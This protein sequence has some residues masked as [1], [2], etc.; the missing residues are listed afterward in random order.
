MNDKI[1]AV[2][3]QINNYNNLLIHKISDDEKTKQLLNAILSEQV[4]SLPSKQIKKQIKKVSDKLMNIFDGEI[5][6]SK[7]LEL[8]EFRS[9]KELKDELKVLLAE[10]KVT[11]DLL[12]TVV[13]K[14]KTDFKLKSILGELEV[15]KDK[16]KGIETK[17]QLE[18]AVKG[19]IEEIKAFNEEKK[20]LELHLNDL[21]KEIASKQIMLDKLNEEKRN[22]EL[23]V[24]EL[25][26]RKME[27]E[28][29]E[30]EPRE[31]ETNDNLDYIYSKIQIHQKDRHD[32]KA[33][34]DVVFEGLKYR[35]RSSI[36]DEEEFIRFVE[37]EIA[38]LNDKERS[39]DGLLSSIS[40]QFA[41]PAFT[42]L[43][44]YEEFK[45][46]VYDKFNTKL[47]TTRISNIESLKIDIIDNDRIISELKQISSIQ[48]FNGQMSFDFNQSENLK[49]LNNYL[50][51]G[52]K[53]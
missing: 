47:A 28:S 53:V 7:G 30:V 33:N 8:T 29:I 34:K 23:R 50:D 39:I 25:K 48:E 32:L 46:F 1:A 42:L 51:T 10:K 26:D 24:K 6:I 31:Y 3:N 49:I 2:E 21:V 17:P 40:T 22:L 5:D 11:E 16:I 43:K 13:D 4:L 44:R 52:K 19:I 15:I 12:K 38:C 20:E 18:R 37:E 36:A 9:V 45:Q 14:E 27:M 35:L 41:N